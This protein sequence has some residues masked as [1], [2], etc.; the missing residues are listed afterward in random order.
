MKIAALMSLFPDQLRARLA[1]SQSLLRL[2]G[3]HKVLG[4]PEEKDMGLWSCGNGTDRYNMLAREGHE[5][6]HR[7]LRSAPIPGSA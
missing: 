7:V 3:G 6:T 1:I 5:S 4:P 2:S